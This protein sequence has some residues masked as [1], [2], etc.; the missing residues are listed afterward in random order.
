[1]HVP[2]FHAAGLPLNRRDAL[3]LGV[4]AGLF[5]WAGGAQARTPVQDA[6]TPPPPDR[7]LMV[8]VRGGR[9]HVRLNG[10]LKSGK[11][12]LLMIHGGPGGTHAGFLPALPL[13]ADRAVILYD[14]LDCGNSDAPNDPR[15]WT[16]ERFVSEVDAVRAAL[17]LH[18]M[19]VLGHSWGGT[20]ALEYAAR[21]PAGLRSVIMQGPLIAT[22]QWIADGY[23]LRSRLPI[24]VQL[25]LIKGDQTGNYDTPAYVEAT[26]AF[27]AQF[28]FRGRP[29]AWL[30]PYSAGL[31]TPFNQR[32]YRTMWGPNEFVADGT[33]KDYAG[34]DLLERI[35]APGLLLVGRH[36]EATPEAMESYVGRLRQGELQVIEDAS[37]GIQLE[38][39]QAW[40]AAVRDWCARHD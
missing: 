22:A 11:A 10:D 32:L 7:T 16:V 17:D 4:A 28:N 34:D 27:Y 14:Q 35:S 19:H 12:P 6:W 15:N 24:D 25:E 40:L 33:L 38:Q 37:H 1:M 5:G 13:A 21:R 31:K 3:R 29:P 30:G 20:I 2:A 8:P 18:E 9:V 39:P 36:D 26:N 23:R